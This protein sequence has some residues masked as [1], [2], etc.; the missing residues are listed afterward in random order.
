MLRSAK[1]GR[2]RWPLATNRLSSIEDLR[3]WYRSWSGPLI[4]LKF[5]IGEVKKMGSGRLEAIVKPK[6]V[7]TEL[8]SASWR[9]RMGEAVDD[10]P[11]TKKVAKLRSRG[12]I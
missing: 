8:S 2:L 7:E 6:P 10:T 9:P 5:D 12:K 11:P 4:W 1:L 3:R